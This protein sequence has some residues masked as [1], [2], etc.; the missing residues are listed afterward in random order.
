MWIVKVNLAKQDEPDPTAV[1]FTL[2]G[3]DYSMPLRVGGA[4]RKRRELRIHFS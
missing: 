4:D 1:G 2:G 3:P